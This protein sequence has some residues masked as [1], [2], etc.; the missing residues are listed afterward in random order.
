MVRNDALMLLILAYAF[1]TNTRFYGNTRKS[2]TLLFRSQRILAQQLRRTVM[3][4][5][6]RGI[7]ACMGASTQRIPQTSRDLLCRRF[8]V[9]T[10]AQPITPPASAATS[11][12]SPPLSSDSRVNLKP[13]V[14]VTE[15]NRYIIGQAKAKRAVAVALRNRW[16][17]HHL[18]AALRAEVTPKN[19]LMIGPTG[20]GKT[21]IA[22]RLSR[23]TDSPFIKV[24]ATKFTE[25]GFYGKDVDSIIKDLVRITIVQL[26]AKRR[27]EYKTKI[28]AQVEEAIL[29]SLSGVRSGLSS[30]AAISGTSNDDATRATWR[31]QLRNGLLEQVSVE[32]E[33]PND[34][35]SDSHRMIMSL[36]SSSNSKVYGRGIKRTMT[37]SECRPV[38]TEVFMSRIVSGNDV[39]KAAIR[40]VEEDGIVFLDE[41]DKIC[42][43]ASDR[44]F[45]SSADASAEGVQRD[46][47]PLIEGTTISTPQGSVNTDHILFICS[48]AFSACKPS[49]LLP[50]LQGRLPIRVELTALS[51]DDMIRILKEPKNNLIQQQIALL[52]TDNIN[53]SFTDDAIIE[54][55]HVACEVNRTIENIGA[56]RLNTVISK[57]MDEISFT[58]ADSPLN[59]NVVINK[60]YVRSKVEMLMKHTD[61]RRFIL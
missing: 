27:V 58:A 51:E 47:L 23:I 61:V 17:R 59:T 57:I 54:I 29:D 39:T 36:V 32:I 15:L 14:L 53:L 9:A 2:Q 43:S 7:V 4:T 50:E 33:V 42:S 12:V 11:P 8:S 41:I 52:H 25:V 49:D 46:L 1:R 20:C 16:R 24:E 28:D 60:D 34:V 22:R 13:S 18:P 3:F 31:D 40:A 19:I 45:R 38:L 10:S 21:E 26:K 55:A 5:S 37:V 35:S 44:A 56:R 48:G 6:A 30:G